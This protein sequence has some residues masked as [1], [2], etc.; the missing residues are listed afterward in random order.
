M[1]TRSHFGWEKAGSLSFELIR[2]GADGLLACVIACLS[3]E[4][5]VIHRVVLQQVA[6]HVELQSHID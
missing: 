2:F 5:S 3:A 1:T 6:A 4:G